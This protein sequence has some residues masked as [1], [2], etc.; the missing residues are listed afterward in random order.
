[1]PA[2]RAVTRT[3]SGAHTPAS[4]AEK[5]QS[6]DVWQESLSDHARHLRNDARQRACLVVE[7]M[8]ERLRHSVR[9]S[10]RHKINAG[11]RVI[12]GLAARLALRAS[13]KLITLARKIEHRAEAMIR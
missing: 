10:A 8:A 3:L 13:R 2:S 7:E 1:M 11:R 6:R 9:Q 4:P 12:K 5:Q